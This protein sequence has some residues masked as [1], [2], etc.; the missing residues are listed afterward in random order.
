MELR[1]QCP[2]CKF[3]KEKNIIIRFLMMM[4]K[5]KE[6][7]LKMFN[8]VFLIWYF[9]TLIIMIIGVFVLKLFENFKELKRLRKENAYMKT[10]IEI[11]K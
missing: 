4:E 6:V 10:K 9:L 7:I 1:E 5:L 11:F 2:G 8:V 3:A